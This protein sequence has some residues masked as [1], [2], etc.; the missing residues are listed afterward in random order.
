MCF[1]RCF[2]LFMVLTCVIYYILRVVDWCDYDCE[3]SRCFSWNEYKR[4]GFMKRGILIHSKIHYTEGEIHYTV[5]LHPPLSLSHIRVKDLLHRGSLTISI[6]SSM[7]HLCSQI[8]GRSSI[9]DNTP[10]SSNGFG[11]AQIFH[12]TW[13]L[14]SLIH[15]TVIFHLRRIDQVLRRIYCE[16]LC[17]H[18]QWG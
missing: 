3:S 18:T 16:N 11:R 14:W 10:S 1:F 5:L 2:S 13:G 6:V 7:N 12:Y 17:P 15:T 4:L 8:W 9:S